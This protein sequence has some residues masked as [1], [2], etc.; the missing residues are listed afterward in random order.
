[1]LWFPPASFVLS[2]TFCL[3][4]EIED[5]KKISNAL[6]VLLSEKQKQEKVSYQFF[7][8]FHSGEIPFL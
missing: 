6:T 4:V 8:Y 5:L 2:N 3:T 7:F 1:M